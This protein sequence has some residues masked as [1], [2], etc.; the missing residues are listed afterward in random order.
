MISEKFRQTIEHHLTLNIQRKALLLLHRDD[1][2]SRVD[3]VSQ[4]IQ[5]YTEEL[6][7]SQFYERIS[8]TFI[9]NIKIKVYM[10]VENDE[11]QVYKNLNEMKGGVHLQSILST[12]WLMQ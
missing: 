5:F 12:G 3:K 2:C 4:L 7:S 1:I 11:F 9:Q 6:Q 8:H 10:R